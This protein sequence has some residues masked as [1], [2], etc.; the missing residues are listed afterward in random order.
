[1]DKPRETVIEEFLLAHAGGEVLM[2]MAELL[3]I[4]R[5][6]WR[7][8]LEGQNNDEHRGRAKECKDLL[9]IIQL[10]QDV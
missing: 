5:E 7:D 4:R 3:T 6:K 8:K 9:Q 10:T 2:Y 1:M